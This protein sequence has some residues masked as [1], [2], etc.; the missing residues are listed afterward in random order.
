[1]QLTSKKYQCHQRNKALFSMLSRLHLTNTFNLRLKF[2]NF[3][4]IPVNIK[5]KIFN[6]P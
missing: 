1:M 6:L 3:C 5:S 4:T 2:K